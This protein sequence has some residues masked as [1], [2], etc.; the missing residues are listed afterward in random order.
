MEHGRPSGLGRWYND[1][2]ELEYVGGIDYNNDRTGY[3]RYY[4]SDGD[5]WEG[6]WKEDK[7]VDC[8]RYEDNKDGTHD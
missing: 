4:W 8:K 5:V 3:G 2:G 7:L 6:M 1:S